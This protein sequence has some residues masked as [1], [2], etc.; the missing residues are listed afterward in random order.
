MIYMYVRGNQLSKQ[1]YA[2]CLNMNN[3]F[4]PEWTMHIT[5]QSW[6]EL[7][8]IGTRGAVRFPENQRHSGC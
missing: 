7:K 6:R 5:L 1:R 4:H 3:F 8:K 2:E